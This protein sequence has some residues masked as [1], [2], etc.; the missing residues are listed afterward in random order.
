MT[1]YTAANTDPKLFAKRVSKVFGQA[2]LYQLVEDMAV[3]LSNLSDE[4]TETRREMREGFA[5][6]MEKLNR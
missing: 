2:G 3:S 6:I 4:L 5:M 1:T